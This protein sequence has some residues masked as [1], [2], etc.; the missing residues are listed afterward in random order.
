ME[1]N[2]ATVEVNQ[3]VFSINFAQLENAIIAFLFE[4]RMRLGTLAIAMPGTGEIA[5]GR[6]SVLV[7]G[8]YL[9]TTRA[10]AERLAGK[11]GKIALVSLYTELGESEALRI[12]AKLLDEVSIPAGNNATLGQKA[13]S[14]RQSV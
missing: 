14:V 9:M 1:F 12:Y 4:D 13:P 6:S 8:K 11:S 5:A 7:G 3:R 2:K 10:L